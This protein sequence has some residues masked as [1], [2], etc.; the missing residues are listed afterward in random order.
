[1]KDQRAKQ[2]KMADAL[3]WCDDN[4][5]STGFAIEFIMSEAGAT[6]DEVIEFLM[7]Q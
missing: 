1:M 6:Q 2:K 3:K 5:K 7:E 4:E